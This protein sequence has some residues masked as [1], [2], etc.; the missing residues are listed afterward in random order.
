MGDRM[1]FLFRSSGPTRGRRLLVGALVTVATAACSSSAPGSGSHGAPGGPDAALLASGDLPST[2]SV[3]SDALPSGVSFNN[4]GPLGR[5]QVSTCV[6]T[7]HRPGLVVRV[8]RDYGLDSSRA[9][10]VVVGGVAPDAVFARLATRALPPSG[11]ISSSPGD[12]FLYV[13]DTELGQVLGLVSSA[14]PEV[15]PVDL[16]SYGR[17]SSSQQVKMPYTGAGRGGEAFLDVTVVQFSSEVVSFGFFSVGQ[18]PSPDLARHVLA[19]VSG[20]LSQ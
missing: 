20:R 13:A 15:S 16:G 17:R 6:D 19:S 3:V 4:G 9:W 12:C 14:I 8:S 10:D 7:P 11:G 18:P 2:W 5:Y 1:G